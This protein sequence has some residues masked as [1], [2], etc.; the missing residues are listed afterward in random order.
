ME[1]FEVRHG[2][3]RRA[4][5]S[6]IKSLE[7]E[8]S[9][10]TLHNE[11]DSSNIV[12]SIWILCA[13][14]QLVQVCLFTSKQKVISSKLDDIVR[15][16]EN[17]DLSTS[18]ISWFLEVFRQ[19][20]W[21]RPAWEE[22]LSRIYQLKWKI[23][24]KWPWRRQIEEYSFSKCWCFRLSDACLLFIGVRQREWFMPVVKGISHD[25]QIYVSI[26]WW[27]KLCLERA[28]PWDAH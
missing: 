24:K 28:T 19:R 13:K 22:S 27:L 4:K 17:V 3:R 6:I 16:A 11:L 7:V 1:E 8:A 14:H 25:E 21:W 26:L 23:I 12:I 20:Q 18:H 15:T 9:C 2:K 10:Q 5:P